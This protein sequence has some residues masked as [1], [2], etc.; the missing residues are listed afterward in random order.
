MTNEYV[1]NLYTRI[2][3]QYVKKIVIP[4]LKSQK[5]LNF[6]LAGFRIRD[7]FFSWLPRLVIIAQN[8][9]HCKTCDIK[10]CTQNINWVCPEN[11]G[12][13]AYDGM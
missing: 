9:I 4:T 11:G 7:T 2:Q 13:P 12:G 8:C 1:E 6:C 3:I 5:I 10:D